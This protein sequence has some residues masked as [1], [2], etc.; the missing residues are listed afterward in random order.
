MS[1]RDSVFIARAS[2]G[3]D[4]FVRAFAREQAGITGLKEGQRVSVGVT[5]GQRGPEAASIHATY[6]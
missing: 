6:Q 4:V 3:K 1:L 2:G 5:E